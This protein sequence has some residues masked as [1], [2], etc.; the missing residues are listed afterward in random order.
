[1]SSVINQLNPS[2][3]GVTNLCLDSCQLAFAMHLIDLVEKKQALQYNAQTMTVCNTRECAIPTE[4]IYNT[5]YA[6]LNCSGMDGEDKYIAGCKM[7]A[8]L[9][10]ALLVVA[11]SFPLVQQKK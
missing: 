6:T 1:M 9:M 3:H 8:E 10:K 2:M 11:N 4:L 5:L 7:A